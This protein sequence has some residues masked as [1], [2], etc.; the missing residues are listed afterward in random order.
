MDRLLRVVIP[1]GAA[2]LGLLGLLGVPA[3]TV[4]YSK[5]FA[6][7]A[8]LF[9]YILAADLIL[10]FVWVI[11]A[12][13]LAHGDHVLWIVLDVVYAATRWCTAIVLLPHLGSV[14]VV[15]GY[16]AAA[17]LHLSLNLAV[18]R[19]RYGLHLNSSRIR[20]LLVGIGLVASLSAIGASRPAS[21]PIV[22]AGITVWSAYAVWHARTLELLRRLPR[23]RG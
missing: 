11:G 3:L 23:R 21:I 7:G 6:P 2:T 13:L 4:L 12:P 22:V 17:A 8:S 9:Q 14:A 18:C 19:F 10:A 1:V 16:L 5:A 15:V 20:A